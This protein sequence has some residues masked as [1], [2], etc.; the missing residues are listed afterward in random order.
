MN[1]AQIFSLALVY[2]MILSSPMFGMLHESIKKQ[3]DQVTELY[4]TE[5]FGLEY[6]NYSW[7]DPL[8][9]ENS[10][11]F[12]NR[13]PYSQAIANIV[14]GAGDLMS[15]E[16]KIHY[17]WGDSHREERKTIIK[18]MIE[19]KKVD[20]ATPQLVAGLSDSVVHKDLP[21][22]RYLLAYGTTPNKIT[23]EWAQEEG[24]F[25]QLFLEHMKQKDAQ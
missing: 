1:N 25:R 19:I 7:T 4:S 10:R 2:S 11:L 5:Q 9:L 24:M 22:T 16:Q 6:D 20:P 17:L 15:D 13:L 3:I 8:S 12:Q 18:R 14:H 21:F 23:I